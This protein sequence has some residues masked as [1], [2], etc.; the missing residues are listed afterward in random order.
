MLLAAS[1][2][3]E[4]TTVTSGAQQKS[5]LVEILRLM[6][7]TDRVVRTELT[8]FKRGFEV[9]SYLSTYFY[10]PPQSSLGVR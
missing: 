3:D 8:E 10:Q 1:L 6:L 4:Q 5:S 9:T 7:C 2:G